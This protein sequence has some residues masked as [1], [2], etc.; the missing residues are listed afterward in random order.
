MKYY[1]ILIIIISIFIFGCK[2]EPDIIND[3]QRTNTEYNN[4]NSSSSSN[5][6]QTNNG[7][8]NDD[9]NTQVSNECPLVIANRG[10]SF[11]GFKLLHCN[12]DASHYCCR[13]TCDQTNKQLMF[14][15]KSDDDSNIKY[16]EDLEYGTTYTF[17]VA[18]AEST[19]NLTNG[20]FSHI[21]TLEATTNY[22]WAPDAY[23]VIENVAMDHIDVSIKFD[24]ELTKYVQL[25]TENYTSSY[26][27][28]PR[29]HTLYGLKPG[30]T[31]K[32]DLISYDQNKTKGFTLS[33]NIKLK[34]LSY[35]N[36]MRWGNSYVSNI[37]EL[38][39]IEFTNNLAS[40]DVVA[41]GTNWSQ[42]IIRGPKGAFVMEKAYFPDEYPII[43]PWDAGTYN[44]ETT[45]A[46]MITHN[47]VAR[48]TFYSPNSTNPHY[49]WLRGTCTIMYSTNGI[50]VD[51]VGES[52]D[53][54][55][56]EIHF[57]GIY[58]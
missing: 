56:F 46:S 24:Q 2:D 7:N 10:A 14:I 32:I 22:G 23:L 18:F 34:P 43:R 41:G 53:P 6:D 28:S 11:I 19:Y 33:Y 35:P 29:K 3:D 44:I 30:T 40:S 5:S 37:T 26:F 52:S 50:G 1:S 38:T 8:D 15:I 16:F 39:S 55:P 57:G 27:S 42:M 58:K 21:Y 54:Y 12:D 4:D 45:S 20:I 31:E 17:S 51:F 36:Y 25:K 49:S 48:A 13:V 9:D 47:P